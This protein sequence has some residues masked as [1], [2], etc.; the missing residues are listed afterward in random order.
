MR[1]SQKDKPSQAVLSQAWGR[2]QGPGLGGTA[3]R[4]ERLNLSLEDAW[5]TL[6]SPGGASLPPPPGT[7]S[8][9]HVELVALVA[10]PGWVG[11]GE[12]KHS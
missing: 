4:E 9:L 2:A 6:G 5:E 3:G 11:C 12:S 10:P 8:V 7:A 1:Q